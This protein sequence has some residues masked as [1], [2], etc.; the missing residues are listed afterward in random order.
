VATNEAEGLKW[1]RKAAEQHCAQEQYELAFCYVRGC[2][3][4]APRVST[5]IKLGTRTAR[6]QMMEEKIRTV[7][8]KLAGR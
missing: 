1:F 6:N 7:E 2:G 3:M 8:V 4:G 5:V